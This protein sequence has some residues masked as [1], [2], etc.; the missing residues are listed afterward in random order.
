MAWRCTAAALV[1][2]TLGSGALAETSLTPDYFIGHWGIGAP[3]ECEASDT[4]SFYDSGAW[5]VTN[6]AGNPVEAIGRWE[7]KDGTLLV[8][9]SDLK[10]TGRHNSLDAQISE[11][12]ADSFTMVAK[13]LQGGQA[14]LH[15]CSY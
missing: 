9:F 8:I 11:V 6:G 1:L 14:P 4:M 3:E 7:F 10:D 15:R 5:A 2:T 12:T 13:P